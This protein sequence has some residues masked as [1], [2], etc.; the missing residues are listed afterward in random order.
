MAKLRVHELAKELGMNTKETMS[1]LENMGYRVTSPLQSVEPEMVSKM[2][3][4][5]QDSEAPTPQPKASAADTSPADSQKPSEAKSSSSKGSGA[6]TP[7]EPLYNKESAAKPRQFS[8]SRDN[9]KGAIRFQEQ[10]SSTP[11]TERQ[12]E[13]PSRPESPS[14]AE[15]SPMY[16]K[17]NATPPAAAPAK[18]A[19]PPRK[20]PDRS[21]TGGK[22]AFD[23]DSKPAFG[24]RPVRKPAP[25]DGRTVLEELDPKE[26]RKKDK[27]KEKERDKAKERVKAD[28]VPVKKPIKKAETVEIDPNKIRK[29]DSWDADEIALGRKR[30]GKK[31]KRKDKGSQQQV[32]TVESK[33]QLKIIVHEAIS[34][35]DFAKAV[36]K[37][38]TEIVAKLI[39]LG[40]MANINQV[41]DAETAELLAD[42][43]GAMVEIR[44]LD[45]EH[46]LS[47]EDDIQENLQSRSPIVTIM[48]HVDHGKT[49]L[50]DSIRS[51]AVVTGEAGGITQHIGAYNVDLGSGK[52]IAFLDTPGH[53]AFT[54]MRARGAKVTD[55]VILVVAADDGV[56][57]QT[58]EAINHA[59]AAGVPI[60]VAVNKI[61]KPDANPQRVMQEL[62][63][64]DLLPEE[65]G[66]TTIYCNISAKERIGIDNLMEMI[67]LQ[68]E[69]LDLKAN[70]EREA[71]GT[72]VESKLDKQRGAVSTILVQN[73][74][75]RKGDIVIAGT[76][77]GRVRAMFD[78][79]GK[80]INE[81][82]PSTPVEVLGINGVPE[83]GDLAAVVADEKTARQICTS[84]EEKVK[85]TELTSKGKMTLDDLFSHMQSGTIKELGIIIKADVHGSAEAIA[86]SLEKFPS[87]QVKLRIIHKGAGGITET[88]VNLASASNAIIIGFSVRAEPK[89]AELAQREGVDVRLYNIIYEV[90]EDIKKAMEGLLDKQ[91][92]ELVIGQASVRQVF[93]V[94]KQG[95]IAGC[96]MTEGKAT[97]NSFARLIRNGNV[98]FK[99]K[100]ASLKRFKDDVKEVVKGYE[101]GIGLDGYNDPI[102]EGD[103][104]EF[105]ILEEKTQ[106]LDI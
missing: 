86:T 45:H 85:N 41:I 90:V 37:K 97:R 33:K 22:D 99:G 72:V 17:A 40:V 78:D 84:R 73:G 66:G 46:L 14:R 47:T 102:E 103:T 87:D 10:R 36:S 101:C 55:I 15:R 89:A 91:V 100:L 67:M 69:I 30:G 83:A 79:R 77:Y 39:K 26:T 52:K 82:G 104:L 64:R 94:P 58:I 54:Q 98:L 24:P 81:A 28:D 34:V 6:S 31:K 53:E 70:P 23:K 11:S 105:Y 88:D 5:Q 68:A 106:T 57:P 92:E 75:L 8:F 18:P 74:T 9:K 38:A 27:V 16:S 60:I 42:E 7:A 48:G 93:R 61:D 44:K 13:R 65:W 29:M 25:A 59:K 96:M 1:E 95:E 50:L 76:C 20:A 12:A 80:P 71:R 21:F 43:Y 2:R 19:G 3:Q 32:S 62:A 35:A 49:S 51:S 63:E 56:M 4:H